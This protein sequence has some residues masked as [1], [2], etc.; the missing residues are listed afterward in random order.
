MAVETRHAPVAAP[1]QGV[2]LRH[3][4][5][6]LGS[7]YAKTL[8][9]S[10]RAFL[11]VAGLLG[12]M[13]LVAGA[14]VGNVY[15]TPQAR[16]DIARLGTELA[17]SSPILLGLVGNPVNIGT[18]GGYVLWKYGPV[19]LFAAV[20]WSILALS[21]TL[22]QE[23]RRG[24]LDMVAT[25]P[26]GRRRLAIEKV[27][28]HVTVLAASMVVL[29]LAAWLAGSAFGTLPGDDIPPAAAFG[30][31][32]WLGLVALATGAVAF[33]LAPFLGRGA[34]AGIAGVVL[35]G[36]YL[37]SG[38]QATVPALSGVAH[39]SWMA[40]TANHLPL[41]GRYDWASLVP[42][43]AVAVVLLVIGVEA[44]ARRDVG[45]LAS[46]R[47]P[48][49]PDALLGLRGPTGRSFA[50]RVPS[51]IAWGLGLGVFG[52]V[53]AAASGTL[54]DAFTQMSPS[55]QQ[56]FR[57]VLPKFDV[58]SAGGLLQLVFVQ[59]GYIVVGFAAVSLV[60]GWTSDE[61][62]GRLEMLL[63]APLARLRWAVSGALG[64]YLAIAAMTA[65]L[66]A[67]IGLGAL[68]GGSDAGTPMA[69]TV[70]LGLFALA[71]AGVGI[72]V[73]G[74]VRAS[75]APE[76]AAFFVI[77]TFLVDLLAPAL[78]A[79]DW[80]H[81]LALT[82]HLGQPMVGSWDGPGIVLCL[83]IA[84][85]GLAIGGLGLRRRDVAR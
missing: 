37:V 60:A 67:A 71:V 15:S 74:L 48:A 56:I 36:N 40:W 35:A 21:G 76:V 64:V 14:G 16:Q 18:L 38:Y 6:G 51:A 9:D 20:I 58:T 10:R 25:A 33:A 57:A 72:A 41:A 49:A 29:G 12:G 42:V 84:L 55:T 8:R 85:V 24:S 83:A 17:G 68:A 61:T 45:A 19:F 63:A 50:D 80:V 5:Y 2:S 13:M 66:A 78:K 31:A 59:L 22:A 53:F 65:V 39:V 47:L 81:Q 4:I 23:A 34:A 28:A 75:I 7:V 44:F 52:F 3:R 77:A 62:S 82:G 26:F 1:R 70:T 11:I 32:L 79:P 73:G 27:A 46:T 30:Y 69:G 43:A 54:G